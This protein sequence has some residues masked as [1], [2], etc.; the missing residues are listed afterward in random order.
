MGIPEAVIDAV[1]SCPAETI[2]H[3]L[4]NIVICGGS[5]MFSGIEKRILKEVRALA[6]DLYKVNVKLAPK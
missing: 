2:E 3:L 5:A 1:N 6:P 4:G